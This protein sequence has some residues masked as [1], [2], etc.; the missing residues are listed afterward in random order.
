MCRP[1]SDSG[2]PSLR[3]H[4]IEK[5]EGTKKEPRTALFNLEKAIFLFKGYALYYRVGAGETARGGA[6]YE[7][8]GG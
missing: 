8:V 2:A 7:L 4:K 3:K 6:N 5:K 1:T